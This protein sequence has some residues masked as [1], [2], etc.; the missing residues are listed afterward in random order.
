[1]RFHY[2]SMASTPPRALKGFASIAVICPFNSAEFAEAHDATWGCQWQAEIKANRHAF[3]I[4]LLSDYQN[5]EKKCVRI[6]FK[7]TCM[8]HMMKK[9]IDPTDDPL[10][11]VCLQL[12]RKG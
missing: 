2:T 10:H 7:T 5:L 11:L 12:T 3:H 9:K 4:L 8:L 1:M 6:I